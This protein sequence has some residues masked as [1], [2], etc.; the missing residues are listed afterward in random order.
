MFLNACKQT[1]HISHV[2][3]ISKNKMCFDVKL[4]AYYFHMKTKKLTDFQICISVLSRF[5]HQTFAGSHLG[6]SMSVSTFSP[7]STDGTLKYL[8]QQ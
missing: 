2:A 3:H 4:S 7:F 1:F 8:L 5:L 6:S